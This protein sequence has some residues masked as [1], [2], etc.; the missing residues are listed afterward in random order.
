MWQCCK[1]KYFLGHP[2]VFVSLQ[3]VEDPLLELKTP[4]LFIIGSHSTLTSQEDVEVQEFLVYHLRCFLSS[5][6]NLLPVWLDLLMQQL[7]SASDVLV[8]L[9]GRKSITL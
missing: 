2:L 1:E 7:S 5:T 6:W 9:F 8:I 3:G 4:T